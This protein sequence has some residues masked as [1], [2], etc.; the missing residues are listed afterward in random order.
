MVRATIVGATSW[1]ITLGEVLA[2]RGVATFIWARSEAEAL[3]FNGEA[4][5]P[6]FLSATASAAGAFD[7]TNLVVWA[8]PSQALRSN[9]VRLRGF[10]KPGM[11]LVSASKGLEMDSG[12]RMSEVLA[13]VVPVALR[14]QICALSGPNLSSEIRRSLPAATVVA[15]ASAAA[16]AAAGM[17]GSP[18]FRI[19]VTGDIIGVE[20]CGAFKNVI[21][22]GAGMM[23]GLGLGDNAKAAF[24]ALGWGEVV[25]LGVALGAERETFYGLAGLGDL[26]ATSASPLSRNHQLGFE[27]G[28]GKTLLESRTA[29][30]HMSLEGVATAAAARLL[31]K[32]SAV[33]IPIMSVVAEALFDNVPPRQAFASFWNR[34]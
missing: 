9:A 17:L 15:P 23:D 18:G 24:I 29:L 10:L 32:Q 21:A 2:R 7:G 22:V 20:L 1:G 3:R 4:S 25:K 27:L 26:V 33:E 5:N 8:V 14:N 31:A 30:P 16:G 6:E 12:K 11:L 34:I 13:D 28:R 19:Q